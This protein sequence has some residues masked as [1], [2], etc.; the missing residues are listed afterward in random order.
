L[1]VCIR[2]RYIVLNTVQLTGGVE[3]IFWESWGDVTHMDGG[4]ESP[5]FAC[6][7]V[8]DKRDI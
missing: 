2:N 1:D 4:Y 8:C 6:E 5:K 3:M 7:I